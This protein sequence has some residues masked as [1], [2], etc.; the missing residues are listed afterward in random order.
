MPNYLLEIGTEELPYKFIPS[1]QMQL[2]SS[3]EETLKSKGIDFNNI[4]VPAAPRRLAVIISDIE[5]SQSDV[6]KKVKGPPASAAFAAN[7]EITPAGTG[8]AKKQGIEPEKLTK[9]AVGGVEY[10]FAEVKEEGKKTSDVLAEII[11]QIVLKLQGSHFMRWEN[12]DIKFSRP[13]RWIVSL[14]D[15]KEVK[16]NIGDIESTRF[17]RGHRFYKDT[18]IEI[19]SPES[20]IE[21]LK[22][23]KVLIKPEERKNAIIKASHEIAEKE[24]KTVQINENLLEE[25]TYITEWPEPVICSFEEKYLE[26]PKEVTITVMASH[27]RYF[28]VFEKNSDKLS[29]RFVT[30]TNFLGENKENIIKGNER[31]VRARLD[32]GI[33]YYKEDRKKTL[34]QRLEDLKGITFQKNLG[35]LYEKTQRIIELSDLIGNE[36]NLGASDKENIKRTALLCKT[37]L[38]TAMVREFTELQGVIGYKYALLEGEKDE[39][40]TGIKEHYYPLSSESETAKSITG[41][42]TGIADK[43]DTICGVFAL[44]KIPTGSADPLGLRRAALGVILTVLNSKIKLNLTQLIKQAVKIQPVKIENLLELEEKV[45]EFIIQRLRVFLNDNNRYDAVEAVLNNSDALADLND[46]TERLSVLNSLI[47]EKDYNLFHESAN[48]IVRIIKNGDA[49]E[50]PEIEL[51]VHDSEKALWN[52]IKDIDENK[53]NYIELV[54]A[55]KNSIPAIERFFEDVLVMDENLEIR[56]N[57]LNLLSVLN[58][59]FKKIADF[60]KIVL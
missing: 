8:F 25:V 14:M 41:L 42:V 59:K 44:G 33:F 1:A 45:R 30:V 35:T 51:L 12:L 58:K 16:I 20:Y 60:S 55:L 18:E 32:D 46:L 34:E 27:Q 48:R 10:V 49:S 23:A 39:V 11:P 9:E 15:E 31:V 19:A 3:F 5:E 6:I 50:L 4:E 2:K 47:E 40:A 7:G 24:N 53:L 13:I 21:D 38:A 56:N 52:E 36:L 28:P 54:K 26:I 29:N 17:S 22:K 43:I 37:D 57:R